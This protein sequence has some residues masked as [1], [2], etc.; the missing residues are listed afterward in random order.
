M[1]RPRYRT[2][3]NQHAVVDALLGAGCSVQTLAA[4]GAG[5][6]DLLVASPSGV[7]FLIEVKMPGTVDRHDPTRQKQ[8][9]WAKH[10]QG[11]VHVIET[12]D[13]ALIL[14]QQYA[15]KEIR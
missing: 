14:A 13:E 2:D 15:K 7:M 6:P 10:W 3:A 1:I 12:A 9:K 11:P 4:V 8:I 5:C